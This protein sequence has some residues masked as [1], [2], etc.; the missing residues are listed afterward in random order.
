MLASRTGAK[1]VPV[2]INS[3]RCWQ[4]K[5]WD[6]FQIP[7]PWAKLTLIIGEPIEIPA[8]LTPE[9]LQE[10]RFKAENELLKITVDPS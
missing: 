7:K 4:L 2:A 8:A 10:Y 1:I 6:R 3:S 5:S 9:Q